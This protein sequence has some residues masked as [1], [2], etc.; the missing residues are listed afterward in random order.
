MMFLGLA[1]ILWIVA[2]SVNPALGAGYWVASAEPWGPLRRLP[3]PYSSV[4]ALLASLPG[5]GMMWLGATIAA[6]QSE[7]FELHRREI[8]DRKRRV[9]E[10]GG[11]GR[12][13]PH[14]GSPI[15]LDEDG[16]PF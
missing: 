1:A 9:A 2:V 4:V 15:T 10:Y 3:I 11:D 5:L 16:R 12:I 7:V 13:E 14:F 6:R 8:A